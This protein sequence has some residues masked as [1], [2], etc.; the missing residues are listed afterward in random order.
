MNARAADALVHSISRQPNF[1]STHALLHRVTRLTLTGIPTALVARCVQQMP[2]IKYL[3]VVPAPAV[4]VALPLATTTPLVM[5]DLEHLS[6]V[7]SKDDRFY[8]AIVAP[9][10]STLKLEAAPSELQLVPFRKHISCITYLSLTGPIH[11]LD[12]TFCDFLNTKSLTV[13]RLDLLPVISTS[14]VPLEMLVLMRRQP[15]VLPNLRALHTNA[16]WTR[17][18]LEV[19]GTLRQPRL[20]LKIFISCVSENQTIPG[21]ERVKYLCEKRVVRVIRQCRSR[22]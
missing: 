22:F 16:V 15:E 18:T 1:F 17:M 7:P 13:L 8:G 3:T 5:L 4:G 6:L 20:T 14:D 11:L 12:L 2:S 21:L 19:L 10:L 9:R